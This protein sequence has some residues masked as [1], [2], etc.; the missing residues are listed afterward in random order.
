MKEA[1]YC[2]VS[3]LAMASALSAQGRDVEIAG[4][5]P[6]AAAVLAS[7]AARADLQPVLRDVPQ[8]R[9][10]AG[11]DE[12][13]PADRTD[14]ARPTSAN[15]RTPGRRSRTCSRPAR[16]RPPACPLPPRRSAPR[17]CPG[18]RR[19]STNT[20]RA[21]GGDPGRVTVR[22]LTSAEYAYAI[23]DLTGVAVKVGVDASSDS[24]GG[25]GFANFGDVQ[26]V[27]DAVVERY[28]E[29]A[30]Q[31]GRSR[32][33]RVG[34]LGLLHRS[35][36]DGPR[37]VGARE[38][39][40]ALP[41][42]R[43]PRRLGRGRPS[44]RL[45]A[46]RQGVLRGLVLQAPRGP[47]RS[48]GDLARPRGEGRHHGPLRR[49]HLRGGQPDGRRIPQP[50]HDRRLA[51]ARGADRGHRGVDGAG[52]DRGRRPH[53]E[54]GHLAELVLRARRPRGGG[55]RRREP[56]GVRRHHPHGP[57]QARVHLS[58][59]PALQP[60]RCRTSP[61]RSRSAPAPGRCT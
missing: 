14:G 45:R 61:P 37:A 31:V 58:A 26:F 27:Q 50:R 10:A 47:R 22:R 49:A 35:R 36:E 30:K 20:T 48:G 9:Q 44:L 18:S 29:A 38:D 4:P 7:S 16:C 12:P 46:L 43:V 55:R 5:A 51:E 41:D 39:R 60:A 6:A 57:V 3:F 15:R 33:H 40:R 19:R 13:R 32:G 2:A 24:V 54:A 56:P 25:E 42:E 1:S 53:Q 23:R 17:R 52:P 34:S 21:S 59:Q 8:R 28:L 11:R